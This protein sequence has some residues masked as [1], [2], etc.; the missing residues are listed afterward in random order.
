MKRISLKPKN[1]DRLLAVLGCL[2]GV[3]ALFF[4][5]DANNIARQGISPRV[6][7]LATD[8]VGGPLTAFS[9]P[10]DA[11]TIMGFECFQSIQLTNLGGARTDIIGYD[12]IIHF[13]EDTITLSSKKAVA[14]SGESF[15]SRISDFSIVILN[16][17]GENK[18]SPVFEDYLKQPYLLKLP[19][20][21]D[22]YTTISINPRIRLITKDSR[23]R[24]LG[25]P[26]IPNPSSPDYN[27][28]LQEFA[29]LEVGYSLKLSSGQNLT[30]APILCIYISR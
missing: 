6:V 13:K 2:A 21:I 5:W 16:G 17:D 12:A 1:L 14:Y 22:A 3:I 9:A 30:V 29:P 23:V 7:V 27:T 4:S 8:S 26:D 10:A 25:V 19:S 18:F 28:F 24:Q 11:P 15:G 20:P